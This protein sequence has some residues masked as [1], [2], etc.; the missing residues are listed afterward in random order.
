MIAI[1]A[2]IVVGLRLTSF[3]FPQTVGAVD[4][5][6]N[7]SDDRLRAI[8]ESQRD[9]QVR[10][11]IAAAD[12]E[13]SRTEERIREAIAV[14]TAT[15]LFLTNEALKGKVPSRVDLQIGIKDG[16]LIPPGVQVLD[17]GTITNAHSN[18]TVHFRLEP[19]TIDV[20][21]VGK[22]PLDGPVLLVRISDSGSKK[23]SAT[24]YIATS[25]QLQTLP[26]P[27]ATEAEIFAL[28]FNEEPDRSLKVPRP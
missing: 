23:D 15:S 27:F 1:V 3:V 28:G 25:L 19:M 24:L 26:T 21:S 16:G 5:H 2:A 17:N 20:L 8:A 11:F 12:G 22:V 6:I 18:L 14:A 13:V 9:Q 10:A 4:P 7:L